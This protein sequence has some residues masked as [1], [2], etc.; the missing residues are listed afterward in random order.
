MRHSNIYSTWSFHAVVLQR[1]AKKWTK[2]QNALTQPLF[3]LLNL[4]PSDA[5]VAVVGCLTSLKIYYTET[6]Y[7][8]P[9]SNLKNAAL[10][11]FFR[12]SEENLKEWRSA[13]NKI[14][15]ITNA[16]DWF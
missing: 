1:T 11:E 4:L 10:D 9:T 16:C 3:L 15:F 8:S 5:P 12:N 6:W 2:I 14:T 13:W 7:E